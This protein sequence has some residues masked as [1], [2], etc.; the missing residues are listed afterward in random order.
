MTF[1]LQKKKNIFLL[2]NLLQ[3][4]N[5]KVKQ[6]VVYNLYYKKYIH[7]KNAI[8]NIKYLFCNKTKK[9]KEK[10]TLKCKYIFV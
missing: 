3:I 9:Y 2:L 1:E 8:N 5:H 6:I 10:R 4:Q 7:I